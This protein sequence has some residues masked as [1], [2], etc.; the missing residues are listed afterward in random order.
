VA[1]LL[2]PQEAETGPAPPQEDIQELIEAG[3]QEGLIE[4]GEGE[5]MQS[6]VEFGDKVV[7]EVMTPRPE[8]AA[9][10]INSPV[11]EL[12]R[13][14]RERRHTRYPVYSGQLDRVEGI[15]SVRDLMEL[16]PE[17]Q[18]KVTLRS[19]IRPVPFVPEMKPLNDLLKDLQQST[20]QM[21]I[22]IDEYGRIS[23]LVT[24]EDL[25]E[26]IVGEIRDEVDPHAHDI[27]KESSTSYLVAGQT[28][29]AQIANELN[30]SIEAADYST[31]AGLMLAQLGHVPAPGEKV[32]KN[33]VTFEVVEANPRT[34][35]KVRMTLTPA[36]SSAPAPASPSPREETPGLP[37]R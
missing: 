29:L 27:V 2:E 33:E 11:E 16:P 28:D 13:L 31:V 20:T 3:E 5:L 6:V 10:E 32:E 19:L 37:I 17:Q 35:L 12:R 7:R 26:E 24:V 4:K 15:V 14:F 21:A 22:V 34:V 30:V 25:V 36:P 9:I 23:G 18:A 8:I 1:R